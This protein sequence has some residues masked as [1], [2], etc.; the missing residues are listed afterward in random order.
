MM[1]DRRPT[2]WLGERWFESE[3]GS[4]RGREVSRIEGLAV[5]DMGRAERMDGVAGTCQLTKICTMLMCATDYNT[6]AHSG[7]NLR[8]RV[9][10]NWPTSM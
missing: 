6:S 4:Q 1:H 2:D 5:P 3:K 8:W 10:C 7:Q 9:W